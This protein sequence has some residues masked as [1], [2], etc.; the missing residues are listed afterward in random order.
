MMTFKEKNQCYVHVCLQEKVLLNRSIK[1]N[2]TDIHGSL[3]F[4]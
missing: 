2:L 1:S 4:S 3:N